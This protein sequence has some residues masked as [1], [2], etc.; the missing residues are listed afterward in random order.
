MKRNKVS[1]Y[2]LIGLAALGLGLAGGCATKDT[3]SSRFPVLRDNISAAKAA[4]AE[5]YAPAPLKSAEVKLEAA[6]QAVRAKEMA[7]AARLVDEAMADA[8]YAR[9]EAPTAKAKNEA[10]VMRHEIEKV[11]T[12]IEQ[13]PAVN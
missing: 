4:E 1:R 3:V 11:R 5:V 13:L 12:E 6:K 7:T 10:M 9:A 8:D 2:L